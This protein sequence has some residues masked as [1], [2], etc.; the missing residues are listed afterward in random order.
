MTKLTKQTKLKPQV[1]RIWTKQTKLT[2]G[3]KADN[4][5]M[6]SSMEEW[7]P[8]ATLSH[9]CRTLSHRDGRLTDGDG[10]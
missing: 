7:A 8:E 9:L 6:N 1:R 10:P 2:K 3:T 4:S 5:S